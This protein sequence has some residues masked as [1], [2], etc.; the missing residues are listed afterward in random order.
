MQ[1]NYEN[2]SERGKGLSEMGRV[3]REVSTEPVQLNA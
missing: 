1:N 3:G 2:I